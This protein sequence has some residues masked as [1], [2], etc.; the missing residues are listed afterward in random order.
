VRDF[1]LANTRAMVQDDSG[2]P[3]RYYDP[4]VW[5]L[6][7]FG[8]YLGPISVFPGRYQ[9]EYAVLFQKAHPIDFG[10]GYRWR[11]S[12]TN[13]LLAKKSTS[14]ISG[15]AK[16]S[17][18]AKSSGADKKEPLPAAGLRPS[19]EERGSE[20]TSSETGSTGR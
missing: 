18:D 5:D 1:L 15:E 10:I 13:L 19:L 7:P 9:R 2:I 8:R 11:P 4:K 20:I 16:T 14:T 12:E 17:A 6:Q 3:L